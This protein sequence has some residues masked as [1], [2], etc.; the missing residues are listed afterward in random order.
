[1]VEFAVLGPLQVSGDR[2]PIE[3]AG[4]KERALLAHLISDAGRTVTTDDLIDSLWGD[5]P[6]RTAAKSLQTHVHRLRNALEPDRHG[7]PSL[8]V[9]EGPGYRLAVPD[10][11]I[12]ASLFARL[13]DLGRRAYL[14]GRVEAAALTLRQALAL[15]RGPAYAGFE[16][17]RFGAGESRRLEELR[18]DALEDRIA[19]DLDLGRAR[20]AVPELESLVHEDP[21]RERL[22]WLLV[23]ALYRAGRQADALGAYARARRILTNELGVEPGEDLRSLHA[24]VLSQDEGLRAPA[25]GRALPPALVPPPGPFVGRDRELALLRSAWDQAVTGQ[26]A[27]VILRGPPG[28]G[29]RRLAAELAVAIAD[30]AGLVEFHSAGIQPPGIARTATLTVLGSQVL[31]VAPTALAGSRLT[32]VVRDPSGQVPDGATVL[33]LQPLAAEHVRTILGNYLDDTQLEQALPGILRQSGGIPGRVHAAAL[34]MIRRRAADKVSAAAARTDRMHAALGL[35]RDDLRSNVAEFHDVL[36]RAP[37]AAADSCPWKGLAAYEVADAPLFAGRERLVADL[38]TRMASSRLLAIVGAS[39]SGK[40]SLVRAGLLA[41]L[42]AGALPGSDGWIQLV[43]RPGPHPLREMAQVALRGAEPTRD[44]VADLLERMVY[45]DQAAG[46]LVLVVDQLEETWTTC[47]DPAERESFLEA[48]ADVVQSESRCTV[49]LVVRAEYVAELADQP[50]LA[51][52]LSDATVLVGA[53]DAAEVRRCVQ[54]PADRAG[55][56]LEIGLAD[57]LV[58]D[59]GD[60]PGSLPLLS[61]A[62]TELWDHREGRLLTLAGYVSAGGIQGA[63]ARIAERAYGALEPADQAAARILLLRLAGPGEGEAV[64]RRRVPLARLSDLPDDRVRAVV[65]PLAD[66]RLLSVSADHVEVAHEALFREWPRLRAWLEEDAAGRAV[67]RR[68]TVAAEE[69]DAAGRDAAELWRGTRLAAGVEFAATHPD[70]VTEIE[71]TFLEASLAQQDAERRAAEE[72]A[73][74]ATRKNRQLRWLLSVL[75]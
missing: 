28:S 65:D 75:G 60:E 2:G 8:L 43:M 12:D 32:V 26:P 56:E 18:R 4:G 53:P 1:M 22:W 17:T 38:V 62:L 21:L 35:A 27:I 37:Q 64:T 59:T 20:E 31:Q 40:S 42:A 5:D 29:R 34:E 69:W 23:L 14:D 63:V 6:P 46:R 47:S 15:W 51:A 72:R 39:G 24:Q 7:S 13:V 67:Q 48:L 19:A 61:T 55:L 36:D 70:E 54:R 58:A 71:H 73:A 52:A 50:V 45:D 30:Q 33:D 68:L 41:S 57:A 44:R 16:Y 49:V 3:I 9:T 11:A 74:V 66:A 10:D 25:T